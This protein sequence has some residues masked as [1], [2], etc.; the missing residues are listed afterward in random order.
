MTVKRMEWGLI[1]LA[2]VG[3]GWGETFSEIC[4]FPGTGDAGD[5]VATRELAQALS[6]VPS[7]QVVGYDY[8]VVEVQ[9]PEVPG[10]LRLH[11]TCHEDGSGVVQLVLFVG[12]N[13][14]RSVESNSGK[15]QRLR[16]LKRALREG[17]IPLHVALQS[18]PIPLFV[19]QKGDSVLLR[20]WFDFDSNL[21][22]DALQAF[23]KRLDRAVVHLALDLWDL[24][25][26]Q[27]ERQ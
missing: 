6:R 23:L 24:G 25:R 21:H 10:T 14:R 3:K 26:V 19:V 5:A 27:E 1:V 12:K 15:Y 22:I 2:L 16:A 7:V 18:L 9:L 11:I 13:I 8:H 20:T 17:K 4:V